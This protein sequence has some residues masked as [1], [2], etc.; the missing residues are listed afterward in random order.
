MS[1]LAVLLASFM[2]SDPSVADAVAAG[3][4]A[5][6]AAAAIRVVGVGCN[7]AQSITPSLLC[8]PSLRDQPASRPAAD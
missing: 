2:G 3:S 1:S 7:P 6:N 8:K 4:K 5:A